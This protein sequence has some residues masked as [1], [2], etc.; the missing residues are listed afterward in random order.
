MEKYRAIKPETLHDLLTYDPLTGLLTWMSRPGKDSWNARYAGR[1]AMTNLDHNGY[2]RSRIFGI[3]VAAHRVIWAMAHGAWPEGDIDHING[4]K[5]DNRLANLR[6][7]TRQGNNRNMS[8]RKDNTSGITG[9]SWDRAR[10]LWVARIKHNGRYKA[11]GRFHSVEA[12]AV[13]R[14]RAMREFGY[15]Q[16][17]GRAA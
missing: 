17:H 16:N 4:D 2:R 9:V 5:T 13:A 1:E 7:V 8:R 12:A 11:L 3:P 10:Q 15:H 6:E 14:E